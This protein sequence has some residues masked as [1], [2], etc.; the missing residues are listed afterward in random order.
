MIET[1]TPQTPG[2]Y[3]NVPELAYH[4]D[5]NACSQSRLKTAV[6]RSFA[7]ARHD[8][9]NP[10][11]QTPS[12][13][14]GSAVHCLALTPHLFDATY[15]TATQCA[16]AKKSGDRCAYE[17]GVYCDG[18]W[19]CKTHAPG[20]HDASLIALT[21]EQMMYCRAMADELGRHKRF[22]KIA[23]VAPECREVTAIWE[24]PCGQLCKARFDFVNESLGVIG[25]IK[26]TK[27]ASPR[28]FPKAVMNYGYGFQAAMYTQIAAGLGLDVEHFVIG[29]VENTPHHGVALYRVRDEVMAGCWD[30][31]Q[32]Y[33]ERY[34]ECEQTG[35]WPGYG[36]DV[37]D[38]DLPRYGWTELE[39]M[40]A[41]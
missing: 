21:G 20:E 29:A 34:H 28:A 33:I 39:L 35:V 9:L 10:R 24:H 1:P 17:G 11:P 31:M 5:I 26:T 3:L 36:D 16:G 22:A 40:D 38:V 6:G 30:A 23:D 32:S 8:M 19:Y 27:D 37:L 25:D 4:R 13:V 41:A 2:L 15:T 12:M 18:D 7:H 14:L